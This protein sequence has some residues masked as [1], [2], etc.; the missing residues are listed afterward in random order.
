MAAA[1]VCGIALAMVTGCA[2]EIPDTNDVPAEVIAHTF[3]PRPEKENYWEPVKL[4][5]GEKSFLLQ[6]HPRLEV[7]SEGPWTLTIRNSAGEEKMRK[8]GQQVDVATGAITLLCDAASFPKGDWT[9]SL[10]LEEGGRASGPS[11]QM[12]RFRVE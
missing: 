2:N 11:K 10:E 7:P 3:V 1:A 4:D 5:R 8:I 6:V 12:F 9:I